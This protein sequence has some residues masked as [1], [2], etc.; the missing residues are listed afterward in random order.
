MSVYSAVSCS[1]FSHLEG[2]GHNS[3]CC[4]VLVDT[5]LKVI[6]ENLFSKPPGFCDS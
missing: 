2:L 6:L 4:S 3:A 1:F 5:E